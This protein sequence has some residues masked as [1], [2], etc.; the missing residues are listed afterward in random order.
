[1]KIAMAGSVLGVMMTLGSATPL[2]AQSS[3]L[4]VGGGA[5]GG[6]DGT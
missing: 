3:G 2:F 5:A 6:P 4:A 1:M